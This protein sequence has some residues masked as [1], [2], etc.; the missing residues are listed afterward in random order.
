MDGIASLNHKHDMV[1][2]I[3]DVIEDYGLK[4]LTRITS[5]KKPKRSRIVKTI[6]KN[7]D[8]MSNPQNKITAEYIRIIG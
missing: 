2:D 5:L 6:D 3:S 4:K 7:K 1:Y 8:Y